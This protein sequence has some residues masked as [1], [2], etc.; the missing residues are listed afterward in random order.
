[1][2]ASPH[3]RASPSVSGSP[4][5]SLNDLFIP[6]SPVPDRSRKSA[7]LA[8]QDAGSVRTFLAA[9]GVV[10]DNPHTIS[11][12]HRKSIA[13]NLQVRTFTSRLTF[14]LN[15]HLDY[16]ISPAS[17]A[18]P[19]SDTDVVTGTNPSGSSGESTGCAAL[20]C[21]PRGMPPS[22]GYLDEDAIQDYRGALHQSSSCAPE[23]ARPSVRVS[24]VAV[25]RS[26]KMKPSDSICGSAETA[27]A[28]TSM[29]NR[30]LTE[31]QRTSDTI[32]LAT[33]EIG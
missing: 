15:T 18:G 3:A 17:A 4:R 20:P 25:T 30:R 24:P 14:E 33:A 31:P 28:T 22:T 12:N 29:M 16:S 9:R 19:V 10:P 32:C 21:L 13:G 26:S 6:P 8:S 27:E 11:S 5:S 23:A 2:Q 1:M 7:R